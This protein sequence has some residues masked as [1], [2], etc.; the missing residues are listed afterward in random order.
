MPNSTSPSEAVTNAGKIRVLF[1]AHDSQL[2]GAQLTLLNILRNL[3]QSKFIPFVV[4]PQSGPFTDEVTRMDIPVWP[5]LVMRWVYRRNRMPLKSALVA[6]WRLLRTPA[7]FAL[8]LCGLPIRLGRLLLFFHRQSIDVVYTNTITVVDGAIAAKILRKP[9]IWHLHEDIDASKDLLKVLPARQVASFLVPKLSTLIAVASRALGE[10]LFDNL[11]SMPKV[12]VIH[13]GVDINRFRPNLPT[14]FL[15]RELGIPTGAPLVGICGAIQESKGIEVF[16]KAAAAASQILSEAHFIIIG[17]GLPKYVQHIKD[18]AYGN[19]LSGKLHF[20]GWRADIPNIF[21]ELTTV[22]ITSEQEAFGLTVIEGMGMGKP[23]ISTRCGG[24]EEIVEHGT[25]GFL[26]ELGNQSELAQR[27]VEII[28]DPEL[29]RRM[30]SAG[31][32]ATREKFS[33]D[34]FVKEIELIIVK[35]IAGNLN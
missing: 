1:V 30:G 9:H 16:V 8:F 3:D 29:G 6:P 15:H 11:I 24:P 27:I 17:E 31:Y 22:V 28:A 7:I 20:T 2:Q 13:N 14:G 32:D 35:A 33:I 23:I 18:I 19:G 5:G 21:R 26:I 12:Q 10:Q 34:L 25:T 4:A